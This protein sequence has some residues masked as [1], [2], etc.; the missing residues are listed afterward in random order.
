MNVNNLNPGS[1]IE[2]LLP[3]NEINASSY[4]AF[5][6]EGKIQLENKTVVFSMLCRNNADVLKKNVNTIVNI[7]KNY[8]KDYKFVVFENDS[9]DNTKQI[10]KQL[11]TEDPNFYY[12]SEDNNK[13]HFGPSK[14]PKRTEALAEYRNRNLEYIKKNYSDYDYVIVIDSDFIDISINGFY[15]SFGMLR[16]TDID[17]ICGN[18]YQLLNIE[19][20]PKL[21]NYDCWAYRATWWYDWSYFRNEYIIDNPMLW[22]GYWIV[23]VGTTPF[24]VNSAFGGMAIYKTQDYILGEY[25]GKDC[26]HVMFHLSLRKEKPDWRLALNPSQIMLMPGP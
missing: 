10:L 18:S 25:D 15:H 22:F 4:N 21:W 6:E 7:V 26:E 14:N 1:N 5:I 19:D 23:P 9:K 12:E 2:K 8:V 24:F 17:A 16:M 3:V 20:K 11:A 13:P